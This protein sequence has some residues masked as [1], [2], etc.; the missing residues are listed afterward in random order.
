MSIQKQATSGL[1]RLDAFREN[2]KTS[3]QSNKK[4][5]SLGVQQ[6]ADGMISLGNGGSIIRGLFTKI[7]AAYKE[8]SREHSHTQGQ[9]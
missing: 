4:L 1:Y 2:F 5:H 3:S 7:R 6:A 8:I 9:Q